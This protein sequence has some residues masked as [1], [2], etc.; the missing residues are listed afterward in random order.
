[1]VLQVLVISFSL[2]DIYDERFFEKCLVSNYVKFFRPWKLKFN[3]IIFIKYF[4]DS[5][6]DF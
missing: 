5:T 2:R 3:A 4:L 1:M 6:Y